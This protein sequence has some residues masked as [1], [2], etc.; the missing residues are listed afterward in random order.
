MANSLTI[1]LTQTDE[2]ETRN[3]ALNPFVEAIFSILHG[4]HSVA[5]IKG[6]YNMT[7]SDETAFDVMVGKV[8]STVD[9]TERIVRIHRIRSILTFWEQGDVS[10]YLTPDEI[11]THLLAI[12]TGP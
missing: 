12:D 10:S 9:L 1:R 6:F 3:I 2:D 7:A 8:T 11:E 5:G 4:S